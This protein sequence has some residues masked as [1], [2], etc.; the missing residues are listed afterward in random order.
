MQRISIIL[1]GLLLVLSAPAVASAQLGPTN[2]PAPLTTPD[3]TADPTPFDE[4][5]GISTLQLVLIF[6]AAIGVL[7]VIAWFIVRDAHTAAPVAQ[8][9]RSGDAATSGAG[10]GGGSKAAKSARERE[11]E[12]RRKRNR[13]KAQRNQRKRNRPR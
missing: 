5:T 8:R 1:V 9:G 3:E 7:G 13:A 6:G 11:R 4:D 2:V 12:K 10:T